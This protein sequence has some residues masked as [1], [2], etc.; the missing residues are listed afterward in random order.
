VGDVGPK[1]LAIAVAVAVVA[2]TTTRRATERRA[3]AALWPDKKRLKGEG[4]RFP[5]FAGL[6]GPTCAITATGG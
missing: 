3:S 6:L 2:G 4:A 1:G 5:R